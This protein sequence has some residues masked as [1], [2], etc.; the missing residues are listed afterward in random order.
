[1]VWEACVEDSKTGPQTQQPQVFILESEILRQ[2]FALSDFCRRPQASLED[3]RA[4]S[5]GLCSG[6]SEIF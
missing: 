2:L 3:S 1:M 6:R 5:M 4:L